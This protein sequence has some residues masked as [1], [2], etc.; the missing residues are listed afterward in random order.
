MYSNGPFR[1]GSGMDSSVPS[2][3][4][5]G[6][7]PPSSYLR[8]P[9]GKIVSAWRTVESPHGKRSDKP[10][11]AQRAGLRYQQR[12]ERFLSAAS[13]GRWEVISSPWFIFGDDRPGRNYCQPDF[14]LDLGNGCCV[15]VEVKIRWTVDAWYQLNE[16]YIPVVLAARSAASCIPLCIT[17]SYDPAIRAPGEV[18]LVDDLGSLSSSLFNLMVLR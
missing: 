12:V 7:S 5:R 18:V 8:L 15:V 1:L 11:A 10:S 13:M 9:K 16:L 17:K 3:N 4:P 14:L 2:P 6:V